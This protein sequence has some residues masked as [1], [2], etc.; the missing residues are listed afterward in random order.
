[1][2]DHINTGKRGEDMAI[3][4]LV[5]NGFTILHRN[6]RHSHWE[7]D[8]IA[9]KNNKL[10]FIEVKTRRNSK[11]GFPEEGVNKK[12]VRNLIESADEFTQ[13]FPSWKF[14]QFDILSILF[15]KEKADI[16]YIEDIY[17]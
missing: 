14:I 15:I 12:K 7:V 6:W 10:H 8:I 1:M 13:L 3:I 17:L 9:T 2:A 16:K 5:D 11:F 4:F